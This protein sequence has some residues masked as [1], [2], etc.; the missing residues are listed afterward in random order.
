MGLGQ[1]LGRL[2]QGGATLQLPAPC[3]LHLETSGVDPFR[4]SSPGSTLSPN[5]HRHPRPKR[6]G[7]VLPRTQGWCMSPPIWVSPRPDG[8]LRRFR[9]GK[10][11]TGNLRPAAYRCLLLQPAGQ[12]EGPGA[13][14]A[15]FVRTPSWRLSSGRTHN[16]WGCAERQAAVEFK[17]FIRFQL[18]WPITVPTTA[19]D[20]RDGL[21]RSGISSPVAPAFVWDPIW[22]IG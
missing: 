19:Q 10:Q 12:R 15:T 11:T 14:G 8:P 21:R 5:P 17:G 16:G 20:Q 18:R 6:A 4:A 9:P 1:A 22:L 7:P 13:G 3:Q 2:K